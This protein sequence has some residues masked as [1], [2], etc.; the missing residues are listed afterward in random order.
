MSVVCQTPKR[1]W[2]TQTGRGGEKKK[3]TERQTGWGDAE[4]GNGQEGDL[5]RT[6]QGNECNQ[7]TSCESL[8]GA[9]QKLSR[10]R[11]EAER[12]QADRGVKE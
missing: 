3:E 2:A 10:R 4:L 8:K 5:G 1:T 12:R 9:M 11:Y 7:N 6:G